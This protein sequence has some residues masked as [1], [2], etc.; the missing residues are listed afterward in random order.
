MTR[1]PSATDLAT[2]RAKTRLEAVRLGVDTVGLEMTVLRECVRRITGQDDPPMREAQVELMH[3]IT[4]AMRGHGDGNHVSAEA[5]TGT[6]KSLSGLV[7]AAVAALRGERTVISTESL[8]LQA[9]IM[10]KD[11]P[12]VMD[13][14]EAITGIRPTFAVHKGWSNYVCGRQAVETVDTITGR[15]A[16]RTWANPAAELR[17]AATTLAKAIGLNGHTAT[18]LITSGKGRKKPGKAA[19]PAVQD[20]AD[21]ASQVSVAAWAVLQ[22]LDQSSGDRNTYTGA[23][24]GRAW[25]S[26]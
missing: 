1:T 2:L 21:L 19:T 3:Q 13:C 23:I 25:E 5:P 8:A 24:T 15:T 17:D 4:A 26:V 14:V 6:G 11:A 22:V 20:Q 18:P 12:L 16:R 10:D 9:Q 7:P